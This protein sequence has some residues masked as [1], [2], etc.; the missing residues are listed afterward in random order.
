MRHLHFTGRMRRTVAATTASL[1]LASLLAACNLD[2]PA[3]TQPS[4]GSA[5]P[6]PA[7]AGDPSLPDIAGENCIRELAKLANQPQALI[8]VQRVEVDATGPTHYLMI[9]GAAAPWACK[10]SPNG[11]VIDLMYTQEG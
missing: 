8:T 6:A 4:Y 1:A 9:D 5:N 7:T 2:T 10:T 11:A 3:A